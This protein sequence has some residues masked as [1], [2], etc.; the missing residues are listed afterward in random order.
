MT[1]ELGHVFELDH[2]ELVLISRHVYKQIRRVLGEFDTYNIY[3]CFP[4]LGLSRK[5]LEAPELH[6]KASANCTAAQHCCYRNYRIIAI[7][8]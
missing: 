2:F 8:G 7:T 5:K 1:D 3:R 6:E 4:A